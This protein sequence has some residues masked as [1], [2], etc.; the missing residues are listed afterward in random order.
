MG[1]AQVIEDVRRVIELV[2]SQVNVRMDA[3]DRRQDEIERR[4]DDFMRQYEKDWVTVRPDSDDEPGDDKTKP[5]R[6]KGF[7]APERP[8]VMKIANV[9]KDPE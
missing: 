7:R 9:G 6:R 3:V 2:K 5:I 8:E 4:F 1:I